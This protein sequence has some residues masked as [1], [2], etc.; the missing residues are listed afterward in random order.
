MYAYQLNVTSTT[1]VC[2]VYDAGVVQ[3]VRAFAPH[4][5]GWVFKSKPRQTEVVKTC[6]DSSTAKHSVVT[7]SVTGPRM[8]RVT[9]AVTRTRTRTAQWP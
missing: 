7:V 4:A 8:P 1:S 3:S 2:A 5:E 9:V 6:S